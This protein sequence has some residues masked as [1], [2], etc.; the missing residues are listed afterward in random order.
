M[1]VVVI[2]LSHRTAPLDVL[3][4]MAVPAPE[5]PKALHDLRLRPNLSEAVVLS[6]C[7]RI[8][9]YAVAERFHA[10]FTRDCATSSPA[11]PPSRRT[12]SPTTCTSTTTLAAG[13]HLFAVAA[14]LDSAVIG[15]T[16]ILGQVG[17]AWERAR[18]E[19]APGPTLN[20]LF[21]HAVEAGKAVRTRRASRRGITSVSQAAVAMGSPAARGSGRPAGPGGR[22]RVDGR[23]AWAAGW[24]RPG[25]A[26]IVVINRTLG[27]AEALASALG[28]R[29]AALSVADLPSSPPPTCASRRTGA[30]AVLLDQRRSARPWRNVARAGRCSWSTSPCPAN[31]DPAGGAIEGVTLLD[32]DDLGPSSGPTSTTGAGGRPGPGH[33]ST[34]ELERYGSE[35]TA[36]EVAPLV[37]GMRRQ[38]EAVRRAELDRV[39]G[40][41]AGLDERQRDAVEALTRAIVAKLLHEPTVQLKDAAGTPRGERLADA[42]RRDLFDLGEPAAA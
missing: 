8:E 34:S 17:D 23:A 31:V 37:L 29:V 18:V 24:R 35:S 26:E 25:V 33:R 1:S 9:I 39:A 41:L 4:R 22:R 20:L 19:G 36:R 40:R 42:L 28:G 7:N 14:G 32:I 5:L 16:E 27:A 21:R 12:T 2:G 3:E 6:T 11:W 30:P 13:P 10:G 38:A 15:E